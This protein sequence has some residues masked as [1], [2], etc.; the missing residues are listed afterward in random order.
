MRHGR[1]ANDPVHTDGLSEGH[2]GR[3]EHSGDTGPLN[4]LCKRRPAARPCASRGTDDRR[5]HLGTAQP[6][7]DLGPN[8]LHLR[9]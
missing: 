1:A 9:D 4:L 5:L 2:D 7:A 6:V 8:T 3:D